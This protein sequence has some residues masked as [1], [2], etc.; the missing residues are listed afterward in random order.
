MPFQKYRPLFII[1][2]VLLIVVIMGGV[3]AYQYFQSLIAP[4]PMTISYRTAET[5]RPD[6]SSCFGSDESPRVAKEILNLESEDI[7]VAGGENPMPDE[8]W[9]NTTIR[10]PYFKNSTRFL[11]FNGSCF[12]RS[13]DAPADCSGTACFTTDTI[14][15]Y[16]WLKLTTVVGNNCFPDT[17]GCTSDTVK[18][19]YVSVNT[20][21]KCHQITFEGTIYELSD[22]QGNLYVM[23]ATATRTPD[24]ANVVLPAG[25]MLTSR[26]LDEPLVILPGGGGD[27]C[28]YNI[29]RDNLVQSYHQYVYADETY[30]PTGAAA[31]PAE[32]RNVH[33]Y[34]IITVT[35]TW[36]IL[37][38]ISTTPSA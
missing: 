5:P 13:P 30:P 20:I 33:Y 6:G 23:H 1:G 4:I 31:L 27:G 16:T 8:I 14:F 19:G 22:G 11:L 3:V 38:A 15:G 25:W 12:F 24:T 18:P 37:T 36:L 35:Q 21:A 28:Y 29:L 34:E 9:Q 17:S 2:G 32:L 26:T 10:L 7:F